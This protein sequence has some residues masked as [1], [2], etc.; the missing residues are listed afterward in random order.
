MSAIRIPA[1][2]MRGGTSKG[3]FFHAHDLPEDPVS[4]DT[5][6]LRLMG[7]PDPY[8]VQIDGMGGG[9]SST[10]KVVVMSRSR[11]AGHDVDYLF[12]AVAIEA[13]MIDWSGNCGN[14][15]AAVGPF[16][17][18]QGLVDAPRD[19]AATVRIWQANLGKTIVATVPVR[20]GEVCESGDFMLDG[21]AFPAS[22]IRLEFLDPAGRDSGTEGDATLFPTGRTIDRLLVPGVGPVEATLIDAGNPA[23][24]VDAAA[25]NLTGVEL[26]EH[27]NSDAAVL[28]RAELLRAHAAVAMGL[29][30]DAATATRNRPAT[31]KLAFIARPQ[32]YRASDG[33]EVLQET[34]DL[35]VRIFSMGRLHHAMTG[36]GAIGIASAAAVPGTVVSRLLPDAARGITFGHPSGVTRV[37]ADVSRIDGVWTIQRVALSRSAR[38]LMTGCVHIPR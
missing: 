37:E 5:L 14:L 23:V 29:A 3:V 25:L 21:V 18:A 31:P 32:T 17:I 7:S 20:D 1:V 6:L 34:I 15:S 10:S 35:V 4:R 28:A 11:R 24:F 13:G 30:P 16:A 19:G 26:R 38:T 36:T 22:E 9:S 33:R 2:F 8:G 27:V 12:G